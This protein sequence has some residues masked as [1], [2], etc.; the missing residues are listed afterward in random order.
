VK[1]YNAFYQSSPILHEQNEELKK[2][3]IGI[4]EK[5]G[6]VIKAAMRLLGMDM[7]ER[8]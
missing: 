5:V 1:E 4:T 2:A 6:Q 8:M 7:P 3:R